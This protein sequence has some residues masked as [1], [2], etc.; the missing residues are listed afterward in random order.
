LGPGKF[1]KLKVS[2]VIMGIQQMYVEERIEEKERER[3]R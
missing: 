1:A 2:V 3:Q